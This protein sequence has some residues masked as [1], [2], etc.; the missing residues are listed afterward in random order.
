MTGLY[1]FLLR[2]FFVLLLCSF[3]SACDGKTYECLDAGGVLNDVS[4][5][6]CDGYNEI[7][8]CLSFVQKKILVD[9]NG[10]ELVFQS[11]GNLRGM[12]INGEALN[13]K[14][15]ESVQGISFYSENPKIAIFLPKTIAINSVQFTENDCRFV[16]TRGATVEDDYHRIGRKLIKIQPYSLFSVESICNQQ[17]INTYTISD[18]LGLRDVELSDGRHFRLKAKE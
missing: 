14:I 3:I 2:I 9:Q 18:A 10:L 16:F 17:P 12:R 11:A 7:G 15:V 1:M 6:S 8:Q 13:V 5:C 4:A